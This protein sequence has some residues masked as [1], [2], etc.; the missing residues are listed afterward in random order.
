M[1][2]DLII[3]SLSKNYLWSELKCWINSIKKTHFLNI[4]ITSNC[5]E[6]E[7]NPFKT[8]SLIKKVILKIK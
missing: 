2:K 4:S 5:L 3:S 8:I 7:L 1:K 6:I